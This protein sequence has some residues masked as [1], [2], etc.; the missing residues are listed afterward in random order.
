MP[1]TF[2][3]PNAQFDVKVKQ[4]RFP[5]WLKATGVAFIVLVIV[6]II[7]AV[8]ASKKAYSKAT[9]EVTGW[10]ITAS[11]NESSCTT[12]I[13]STAVVVDRC[14]EAFQPNGSPYLPTTFVE[15]TSPTS[16]LVAAMYPNATCSGHG[17]N[18]TTLATTINT[19]NLAADGTGL[20]EKSW[21]L[22]ESSYTSPLQSTFWSNTGF[23]DSG[24]EF[25]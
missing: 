12:P 4:T 8:I 7:P 14:S 19:C 24:K 2:V 13:K 5:G 9:H 22:S 23:S 15:Y 3:I 17:H 21:T 6:I 10:F 1:Q 25:F 16:N 20:Y 18:V 11:Y